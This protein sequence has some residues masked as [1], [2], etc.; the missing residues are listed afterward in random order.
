MPARKQPT[1]DALRKDDDVPW[2]WSGAGR[3]A[4]RAQRGNFVESHGG[5]G[6][7]DS[8]S[9][10]SEATL[11][12]LNDSRGDISIYSLATRARRVKNGEGS[13]PFWTAGTAGTKSRQHEERWSQPHV[14][15]QP[16]Q[17]NATTFRHVQHPDPAW[18]DANYVPANPPFNPEWCGTNFARAQHLFHHLAPQETAA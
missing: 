18:R 12:R 14:R 4:G 9:L 10:Q 2:Q 5:T 7:R 15:Q 3:S 1:P 13:D 8:A 16:K 17:S 6:Q 11:P